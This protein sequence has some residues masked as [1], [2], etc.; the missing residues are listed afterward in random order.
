MQILYLGRKHNWCEY[1]QRMK[2]SRHE[3]KLTTDKV[4]LGIFCMIQ[5]NNIILM[6]SVLHNIILINFSATTD[7]FETMHIN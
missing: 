1:V 4:L 5:F 3:Q 6:I 7:G 2:M